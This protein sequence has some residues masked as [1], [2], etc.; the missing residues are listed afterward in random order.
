MA[1]EER[2]CGKKEGGRKGGDRDRK[3]GDGKREED[4]GK[5]VSGM[6]GENESWI[7]DR[8]DKREGERESRVW[9]R[10]R[11]VLKKKTGKGAWKEK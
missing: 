1:D 3:T 4:G 11:I 8:K 7:E 10:G 2:D 5:E 9:K 6:V